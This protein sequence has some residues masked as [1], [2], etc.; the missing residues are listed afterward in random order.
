MTEPLDVQIQSAL[1]TQLTAAP[2]ILPPAQTAMPFTAFSPVLNVPYLEAHRIMRAQPQS[3]GVPFVSFTRYRGIFQVDAVVPDSQGEAP[4]LRLASLVA[5]RFVQGTVLF[6]VSYKI[7]LN[8][9][10]AIGP[11][12][13]DAPWVRYPVS[14]PYQVIA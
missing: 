4:G 3:P 6:T 2:A 13:K 5:A 11:A 8:T 10:P 1:L 7:Q 12:V 14:I 9:V